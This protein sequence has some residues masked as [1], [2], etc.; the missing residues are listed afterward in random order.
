M[1]NIAAADPVEAILAKDAWNFE[2]YRTLVNELFLRTDAVNKFRSILAGLEAAN[3]Q[4]AGAAALKI[5]IGR[6]MLC[7]FKDALE[8]LAQ[9]TDNKDCRCFQA[10]CHKNLTRYDKAIEEFQRAQSRGWD[11]ND[12]AIRVAEC[13]ALAGKLDAAEASIKGLESKLAGRPDY[14][15]IRGLVLELRGFGEQAAQAYQKARE[16]QPDH[17]EA[18]FRLAY[19]SDLHGDEQ[20]ALELYQA[21][22]RRPPVFANALINLSVLLED[23]EQYDRAIQCLKRLLAC[24][25]NHPRAKLFLKDA[26][27]SQNMHYDEDQAK[28]I[29]RR[30]AV[31]DIPVTDFEL[32]VRARNC[33]KKMNIRTLGDLVR[34]SEPELLGYKNFGETSLKEI[35]EML[36]AKGLRLGQALEEGSEMSMPTE[37]PVPPPPSQDAGA[38]AIPLDQVELS[39]RARKAL[40]SLK[41]RTLGDLTHHTEGELLGCR[42]FGQTS[43]NEVRERLAEYGLR[44]KEST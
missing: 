24:D 33:L 14:Q 25:P 40:D 26:E 11:A 34:T 19:Y 43:L 42:N 32:S 44:L 41:I 17:P 10:L 35:K 28:R 15:Y 23:A 2:D 7:R 9:A 21:C 36:S 31:L 39:V 4:A 1:E 20:T 12:V 6:Y 16:L 18:T 27:A 3:P 8:A 37:L 38:M 5:G 29:A 22:L 13:Q 30:N